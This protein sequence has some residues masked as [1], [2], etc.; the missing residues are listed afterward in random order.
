MSIELPTLST[1]S[2]RVM[3]R[4]VVAADSGMRSTVRRVA[5]MELMVEI[6]VE[7]CAG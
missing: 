2:S 6:P 5:G 7:G 1:Y 3:V 4:V